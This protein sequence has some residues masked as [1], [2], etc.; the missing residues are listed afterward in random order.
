MKKNLRLLC[1]GLATAALTTSFAQAENVTSKLLN[2]DME[3]GVIGWSI[4]FDSHIWK[5]TTKNQIAK[6]GF[7]GVNNA[8]LCVSLCPEKNGHTSLK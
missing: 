4:E 7:H 1:L 2:A 6:P 8:A 3:R 5:K